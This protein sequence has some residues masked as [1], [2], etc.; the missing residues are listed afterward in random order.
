MKNGG[1]N[2]S[3]AF[4]IL[5]SVYIKIIIFYLPPLIIMAFIDHEGGEWCFLNGRLHPQILMISVLNRFISVY[6]YE[7]KCVQR[8]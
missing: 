5:L 4:I 1:K 6:F 8:S 2:K 7:F 3:V